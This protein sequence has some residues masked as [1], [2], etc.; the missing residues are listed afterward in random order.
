LLGNTA[1]ANPR[2]PFSACKNENLPTLTQLGN[3]VGFPF[4]QTHSEREEKD[5][6]LRENVY[7]SVHRL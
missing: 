2:K 1:T 7:Y 3:F 5:V 6:F 4:Q